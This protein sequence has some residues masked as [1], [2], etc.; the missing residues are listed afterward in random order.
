MPF[1][2]K[3]IVHWGRSF[4]EYVRMF[5]LSEED[6]GKRILGCG[7]GPASFNARLTRS[8]GAAVSIDPIYPF[9]PAEI[10]A[11]IDE[12]APEILRQLTD[13]A[14]DYVWNTIASPEELGRIR[15]EAMRDFLADF[16]EGKQDGRY[17]EGEL[18]KLP[19]ANDRFDLALSSHVLL[20]YD[21]HLSADFHERA[22]R[23]MLRVA[24]EVRIFPTLSLA[25]KP[26]RHLQTLSGISHSEG[27]FFE[28]R[29]ADYEFQRGADEMVVI[30][31]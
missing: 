10:Q 3:E 4:E 12:V 16:P 13:N 19:F 8:G 14:E 30:R 23:E 1:A 18:P 22:V 28:V 31:R 17:I 11:R 20:L 21:D 26:S 15:M 6:L 2:L 29:K 27:W 24:P 7:D 9:S 5:A 25:G